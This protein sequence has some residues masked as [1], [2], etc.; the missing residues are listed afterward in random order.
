MSV[1]WC[2]S[3]VAGL[4]LQVWTDRIAAGSMPEGGLSILP[5]L[6]PKLPQVWC[7]RT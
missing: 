5:Q 7:E 3:G 2:R 1:S 6:S 4:V